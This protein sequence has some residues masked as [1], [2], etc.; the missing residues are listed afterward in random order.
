MSASHERGDAIDFFCCDMNV[1]PH[2]TVDLLAQALPLL[3]SGAPFVLTF[4]NGF[5]RTADWEAALAEQ[6]ARTRTYH[7]AAARQRS[8]S[9]YTPPA[10]MSARTIAAWSHIA[11]FMRAVTP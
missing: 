8:L 11:A 4:K 2:E 9:H 7:R 10:S 6:H 3:T 1:R 5:K